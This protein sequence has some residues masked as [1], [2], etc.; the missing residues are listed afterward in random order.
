ML[1]VDPELIEKFE[2]T[3]DPA[4]PEDGAVKAR[5]V[6]YGEMSTVLGFDEA[7]HDHLVFK[8]MALFSTDDEVDE[9][10]NIYQLYNETLLDIGL[11]IPDWGML[12]VATEWGPVL[13]LLQAKLPPESVGH[14]LIHTASADKSLDLVVG[15][16]GEL[17]RVFAQ[18]GSISSAKGVEIGFDA[19]I[20]N[21]AVAEDGG[22]PWYFDTSTPLLRI[23]GDEQLDP[24]LFLR[25]C[26]QSMQWVIRRFLLQGVLD[27]YYVLRLVLTDLVA[28]LY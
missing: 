17:Q 15:I 27:R 19:Q 12:K 1:A 25:I 24:E 7:G 13:Y 9:Y 16:L 20:S 22:A 3:M 23:D 5:V 8:R 2:A 14:K 10:E 26:P 11:R 4:H 21:W 18:N 6:G 28:N